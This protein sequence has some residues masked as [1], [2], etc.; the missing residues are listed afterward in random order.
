VGWP[1]GEAQDCKSCYT[2]SNPVPTSKKERYI[3]KTRTIGA[4]VAHFLDMEGVTGS[5]P[6]SSTTMIRR[7]RLDDVEAIHQLIIEL[8]IYEKEPNAVIGTPEHLIKN[9][10][11]DS[12][13]VFC[14]VVE[15]NNEIVGIAIWFNNYST[16]EGE[17][18][19]YL[20]DLYIKPEHRGAGWGKAL[21][22][23]LAQEC[24]KNGWTRFQWWVL[25]WNEPSIEFYKSLGSIPMDEWTV[26][27]L[28]GASLQELAKL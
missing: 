3:F 21:L 14:E 11:S 1:R 10:F 8:A 15:I 19:I 22:K 5:I 2:G 7:A 16:W 25:D 28:S 18:G 12:P 20:E 26:Y 13:K 24:V 4:A 9:L 23:H 17:H 27:R 6:V